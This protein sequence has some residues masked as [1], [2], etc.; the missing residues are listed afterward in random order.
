MSDYMAHELKHHLNT[1]V[2]VA[3]PWTRF[4]TYERYTI[5]WRMGAGEDYIHLW[6]AY[7]GTLSTR[8]ALLTHL[9]RHGPAPMT[10]GD[11]IGWKLYPDADHGDAVPMPELLELGLV[12][13]DAA[14]DQ[15]AGSLAR[16]DQ[17]DPTWT[18][19]ESP[20]QAARYLTRELG[21]HARH[22]HERRAPRT[23]VDAADLAPGWAHMVDALNSGELPPLDTT[24]GL[25][26]LAIAC[27]ANHVPGPWTLGMS[28]GD[29]EDSFD[30]DM[31]Y[32]DAFRLWLMSCVDDLEQ[33]DRLLGP[34]EVPEDWRAWMV[35]QLF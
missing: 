15:F 11:M 9:R 30:M 35:G 26:S 29:Y 27:A 1:H 13:S 33:L 23:F 31:N 3:P 4:P 24:Q 2:D 7:V 10:W 32:V 20:E 34:D 8:D 6:H 17:R 5:G 18:W 14:L 16:G 25:A 19:H 12:A 21:L 22:H 28:L